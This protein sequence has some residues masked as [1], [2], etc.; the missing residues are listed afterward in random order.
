MSKIVFPNVFFKIPE[1]VIY[2]GRLPAVIKGSAIVREH[3]KQSSLG[4][5]Y[6]LP[7]FQSLNRVC[8]MLKIM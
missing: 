3:K 4:L 5:Q 8:E 6:A 1:H 2:I 7:F